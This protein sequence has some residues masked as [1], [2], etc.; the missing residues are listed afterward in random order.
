MPRVGTEEAG[1]P[2]QATDRTDEDTPLEVE[3][4]STFQV[5]TATT[6]VITT[7]EEALKA[8]SSG[9]AALSATLH[10]MSAFRSAVVEN[11]KVARLTTLRPSR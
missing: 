4:T 9:F 10:V 2:T 6:M 1:E 5:A 7:V 11:R 3:H 8:V